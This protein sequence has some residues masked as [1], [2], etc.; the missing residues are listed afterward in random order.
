M[1]FRLFILLTFIS[2]VFTSSTTADSKPNIV[3]FLVDDMGWQDTSVPFHAEATLFNKHYRTPGMER[4]A[5]QGIKFSQAYSASVCSPTRTS[6]LMGQSPVRHHV[7][8]WTLFPNKD[9]SRKSKVVNAPRSWRKEGAQPWDITLPSLL[10]KA[11]YRTIHAGKAHFGAYD[12]PG[13]DPRNLGFDVNIAGHAAGGPGHFHGT[14]NY[15]N[16]EKGGH[17]RPW[18]VTGLEKYHGTDTH[19]TDATTIEALKEVERSV[20]MKKPFYLYLAHYA[21]HAPI[22]EHKP[23]VDNYRGKKYPGTNVA[24]DETEARYASMVEGMDASLVA[25]QKKLDDLRIAKNTLIIFTS[26]NGGLTAHARGNSPRTTGRDSHNYPLREGKGSCYEGGTRVPFLMSWAEL[27]SENKFQ[28]AL[29]I[30][31]GSH[32]QATIICEDL[33]PSILSWAGTSVPKGHTVDGRD[34]TSW[35]LDAKKAADSNHAL[36]FHYPHVWGPRRGGYQPHSAIRLGDWKAIHFYQSGTW[37]L[38][39][40]AADI[41][42]RTN[43]AEKQPEKLEALAR[44]MKAKFDT[45]GAQYPIDATTPKRCSPEVA[46]ASKEFSHRWKRSRLG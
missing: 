37:E 45:M 18:G 9:Q 44:R 13:S 1:L 4:L 25:L 36:L 32:S 21:V 12:T 19:L 5:K 7:T 20:G 10:K 31:A 38:Y 26:D 29:P 41:G 35:V 16:K 34:I 8:N 17:T 6:I 11:G 27:D 23:Y 15:G 28:K 42:E 30:Q 22:Q 3:L 40:L 43:L 33:F 24:I 14:K 39:N 2:C 46:S